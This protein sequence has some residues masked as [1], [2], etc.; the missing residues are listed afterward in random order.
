MM[1]ANHEAALRHSFLGVYPQVVMVEALA[2]ARRGQEALALVTRTFDTLISPEVGIHVPELWRLRAELALADSAANAALAEDWL[3]TA[4]RIA[5]DQGATV[6]QARAE[7][8][9]ARLLG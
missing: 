8:A 4:L 9:L 1:E 5:S 6:Y 3:R 7:S 2:R